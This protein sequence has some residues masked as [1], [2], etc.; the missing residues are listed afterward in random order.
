MSEAEGD[1]KHYIPLKRLS[2][3]RDTLTT[4]GE[5]MLN[6]NRDELSHSF[7][8][9]FLEIVG[10]SELVFSFLDYKEHLQA[11]KSICQYATYAIQ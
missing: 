10:A 4:L 11:A 2:I 1:P 7:Q 5:T 8:C 6:I 9:F 3:A